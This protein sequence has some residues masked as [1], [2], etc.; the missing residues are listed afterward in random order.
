[1]NK[2]AYVVLTRWRNI[3]HSLR[4]DGNFTRSISWT[5]NVKI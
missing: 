1:M 5:N 3:T 2:A 4:Y